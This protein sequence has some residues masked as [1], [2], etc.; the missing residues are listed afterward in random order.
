MSVA[1]NH[2]NPKTDWVYEWLMYDHA[3]A[4]ATVDALMI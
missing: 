2:Q 3:Y 1:A 4:H